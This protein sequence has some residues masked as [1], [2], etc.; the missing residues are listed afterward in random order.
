M[1]KLITAVCLV[2]SVGIGAIAHA[3]DTTTK[4]SATVEKESDGAHSKVKVEKKTTVDAAHRKND[5]SSAESMS[6]ETKPTVAGG[7]ETNIEK[8]T[9]RK[10]AGKTHKSKMKEKIVKDAAGNVVMDEKNPSP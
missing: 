8:S 7:T 1:R 9:T 10:V 5:R 4:T 2:S 3:E 6:A